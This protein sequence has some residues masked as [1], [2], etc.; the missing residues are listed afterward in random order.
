M[1]HWKKSWA[2]NSLV[3]FEWHTWRVDVRR[4]K[5]TRTQKQATFSAHDDCIN[6]TLVFAHNN[7]SLTTASQTAQIKYH[8]NHDLPDELSQASLVGIGMTHRFTLAN[9]C[10]VSIHCKQTRSSKL[11]IYGF[12]PNAFSRLTNS[13]NRDNKVR[14]WD[15]LQLVFALVRQLNNLQLPVY[16]C[17]DM[18]TAWAKWFNTSSA[19]LWI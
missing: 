1:V 10:R 17:A 3:R 5:Y 11:S 9:A 2:A 7:M 16:E 8:H 4:G 15:L 6:V 12:G 18:L 13:A 14:C 19:R